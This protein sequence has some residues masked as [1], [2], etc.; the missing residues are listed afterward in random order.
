MC[1]CVT[2]IDRFINNGNASGNPASSSTTTYT[3]TTTCPMASFPPATTDATSGNQNR[4]QM[5][6]DVNA[7]LNTLSRVNIADGW[8]VATT[9]EAMS[10][11]LLLGLRVGF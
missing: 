2:P 5:L 3:T 8:D 6:N 10:D 11:D 4:I 7:T 1:H 9:Q